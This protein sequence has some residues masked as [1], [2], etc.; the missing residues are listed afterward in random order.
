MALFALVWA[1]QYWVTTGLNQAGGGAPKASTWLSVHIFPNWEYIP[2]WEKVSRWDSEVAVALRNA[3]R[4][5]ED[6]ASTYLL[7]RLFGY[8]TIKSIDV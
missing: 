7:M 4:S 6:G 1:F 8:K 2:G 5:C 3:L